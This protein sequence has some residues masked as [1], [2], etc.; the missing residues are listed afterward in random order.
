MGPF[1]AALFAKETGAELAVPT[2]YDNPKFPTDLRQVEK[3]F[4]EQGMNHRV[5]EIKESII[6]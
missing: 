1:E 5:L 4:I 2:H 6:I 3:Q